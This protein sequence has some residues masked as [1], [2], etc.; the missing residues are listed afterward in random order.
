MNAFGANAGQPAIFLDRDGVINRNRADHVK[1]WSEFEFLPGALNALQLLAQ[2][3]RPI[4]VVSN[5]AAIGRGLATRESVE[6]IHQQM[7]RMVA[8]SG[9]RIDSVLYCPHRPEEACGCRKPEPGLLLYAAQKFNI[10]LQRSVLVGDAVSDLKAAVAVGCKPILVKS[11]RGQEQLV[12]ALQMGMPVFHVADDLL[13][14]ATWILETETQM[15]AETITADN[16]FSDS[17]RVNQA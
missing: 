11:G 14:A 4:V 13:A 6:E 8:R 15:D 16:H 10:D 7:R 1:T 17:L 5:Q 2:L 3:Q 9:G 12:M